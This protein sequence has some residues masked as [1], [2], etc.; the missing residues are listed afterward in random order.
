MLS[1]SPIACLR[2]KKKRDGGGEMCHFGGKQRQESMFDGLDGV[3][4]NI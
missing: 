3:R 2:L 4:L 1:S